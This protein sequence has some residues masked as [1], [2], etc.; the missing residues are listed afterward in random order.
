MAVDGLYISNLAFVF[1]FNLWVNM[2]VCLVLRVF[3]TLW[4][5][6]LRCGMLWYG[7]V[8]YMVMLKKDYNSVPLTLPSPPLS[9]LTIYKE[10]GV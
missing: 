6:E 7:M 5:V 4:R 1:V 10:A 8:W 9:P 2:Y 3:Y